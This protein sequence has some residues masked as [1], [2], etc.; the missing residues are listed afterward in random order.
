MTS[1][2]GSNIAVVSFKLIPQLYA[3]TLFSFSELLCSNDPHNMF[4]SAYLELR[5]FLNHLNDLA[6]QLIVG[7]SPHDA[8][9]N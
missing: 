1:L 4:K 8:C 6:D 2:Q 3:D 7:G 9:S 5:S